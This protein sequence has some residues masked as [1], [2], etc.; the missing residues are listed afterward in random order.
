M[1][2]LTQNVRIYLKAGTFQKYKMGVRAEEGKDQIYWQINWTKQAVYLCCPKYTL[3][4]EFVE[5]VT[6]AAVSSVKCWTI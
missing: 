5:M 3:S 1:I 4:I 2:N 6:L